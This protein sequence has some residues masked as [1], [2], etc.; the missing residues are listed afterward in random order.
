MSV[1]C[2][3]PS[4]AY[5]THN[6]R[7]WFTKSWSYAARLINIEL[8]IDGGLNIDLFAKG[9]NKIQSKGKEGVETVQMNMTD[10][11]ISTLLHCTQNFC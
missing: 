8:L 3:T 7:L 11:Q 9:R 2:H 5:L 1:S 4:F 10:T 6:K